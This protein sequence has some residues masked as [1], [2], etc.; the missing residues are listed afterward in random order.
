MNESQNK[1]VKLFPSQIDLQNS[2][3]FSVLPICDSELVYL[4]QTHFKKKLRLQNSI[5]SFIMDKKIIKCD[6]NNPN[7]YIC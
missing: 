4:N 2:D 6:V 7:T 1:I 5:N 3:S